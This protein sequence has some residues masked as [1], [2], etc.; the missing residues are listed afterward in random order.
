LKRSISVAHLPKLGISMALIDEVHM[1]YIRVSQS[2]DSCLG[3][4]LPA[5]FLWEGYFHQHQQ[6]P[7]CSCRKCPLRTR[8]QAYHSRHPHHAKAIPESIPSYCMLKKTSSQI[9]IETPAAVDLLLVVAAVDESFCALRCWIQN[10]HNNHFFTLKFELKNCIFLY[11]FIFS[12]KKNKQSH[13]QHTPHIFHTHSHRL[14]RRL[15]F[16]NNN[17]IFL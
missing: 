2:I 5:C 10:S 12:G 6:W 3:S 16:E 17:T 4:L 11:F 14:L 9:K 8:G 15:K 1:S 7:I 13:T